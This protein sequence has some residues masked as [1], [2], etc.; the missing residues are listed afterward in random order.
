LNEVAN[1]TGGGSISVQGWSKN[2][3]DRAMYTSYKQDL[4]RRIN[5][6]LRNQLTG[7]NAV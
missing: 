4:R 6:L 3:G 7:V 5:A 1:V 2:Y